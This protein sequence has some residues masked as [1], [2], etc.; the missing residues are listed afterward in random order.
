M[1]NGPSRSQRR[2]RV[3]EL[4]A[5]LVQFRQLVVNAVCATDIMDKGLNFELSDCPHQSIVRLPESKQAFVADN[6]LGD[7]DEADNDEAEVIMSSTV[8]ECVALLCKNLHC[9]Q[10][11]QGLDQQQQRGKVNLPRNFCAAHSKSNNTFMQT[12]DDG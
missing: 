11:L 2:R 8:M 9:K 7:G 3:V 10:Q 1:R 6:D 5:E 12:Q 4:V